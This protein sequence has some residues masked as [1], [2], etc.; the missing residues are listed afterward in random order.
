[1]GLILRNI[2]G[3]TLPINDLGISLLTAGEF[4]LTESPRM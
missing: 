2:S 1:M 4:D 3:A